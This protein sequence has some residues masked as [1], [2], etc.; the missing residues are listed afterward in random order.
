MPREEDSDEEYQ[1]SD[2]HDDCAMELD[3]DGD[4]DEAGDMEQTRRRQRPNAAARAQRIAQMDTP[5]FCAAF[6]VTLPPLKE[7]DQAIR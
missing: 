7:L 2:H 5:S 4:A 3:F 1:P 6:G